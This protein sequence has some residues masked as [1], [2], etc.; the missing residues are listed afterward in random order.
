MSASMPAKSSGSASSV[1]PMTTKSRPTLIRVTITPLL[2]S[3]FTT[4]KA[5]TMTVLATSTRMVKLVTTISCVIAKNMSK[6]G[7]AIESAKLVSMSS[8]LV[9]MRVLNEGVATSPSASSARRRAVARPNV[10]VSF[11]SSTS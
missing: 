3:I 6:I 8:A 1:N 10:Y 7:G 4:S 5:W 11:R 9:S 2:N